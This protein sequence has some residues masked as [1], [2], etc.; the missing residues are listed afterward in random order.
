MYAYA[1]VELSSVLYICCHWF[2]WSNRSEKGV[3]ISPA[4]NYVLCCFWCL[5]L[6]T[7]IHTYICLLS[8]P[9]LTGPSVSSLL[10]TN[11]WMKSIFYI[12]F[13]L[14]ILNCDENC[15]TF[16]NFRY[17]HWRSEIHF[18]KKSNNNILFSILPNELLPFHFFF[19][20]K[21]NPSIF[22]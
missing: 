9:V 21:K 10:E 19:V 13:V 8:R 16:V 12:S 2:K 7:Y 6:H 15:T 18:K 14:C 1:L 5:S 17:S 22:K 3:F 4:L 20:Y 11:V